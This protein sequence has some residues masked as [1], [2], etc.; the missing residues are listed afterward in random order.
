MNLSWLGG[1][2]ARADHSADGPAGPWRMSRVVGSGSGQEGDHSPAQVCCELSGSASG[3]SRDEPVNLRPD[4]Q[5]V[6]LHSFGNGID[7]AAVSGIAVCDLDADRRPEVL[8]AWYVTDFEDSDKN[9]RR[10]TVLRPDAEGELAIA[11]EFDLFQPHV[12]PPLSV[13][14][15]GTGE[16]VPGDFDGDGDTDVAVLPFFNDELWVFENDGGRLTGHVMLPFGINS[17]LNGISPPRGFA[18]DFDG[19]GRDELVYL[20]D[21]LQRFDGTLVHFW[22]SDGTISGMQRVLWEGGPGATAAVE[23]RALVVRDF[24]GDGRPDLCFS[25]IEPPLDT[26]V[27]ELWHNL[28]FS[29]G[30]FEVRQFRPEWNASDLAVADIFARCP[31]LLVLGG[32]DG[33]RVQFWAVDACSGQPLDY[34]PWMEVSGLAGISPQ[35]GLALEV[36]RLNG[37]RV[38]QIVARQKLGTPAESHQID[39]LAWEDEQFE[40]LEP[41]PVDAGGFAP[42]NN[43]QIQRPRALLLADVAGNRRPELIVGFGASPDNTRTASRILP[44]VVYRNGCLGDI[45]EDGRTSL[46]DLFTLFE[47]VGCQPPEYSRAADLNKDGCVDLLD[48]QLLMDDMGCRSTSD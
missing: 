11:E 10:L 5:T 29:T 42:P 14:S 9:R 45:N 7:L 46:A 24:D 40:L 13:F 25:G 12:I 31:P 15:N 21:P 18:A 20:A 38:P 33:A 19:D 44:L 35:F 32:P 6:V 8:V 41:P 2:G 16:V 3:G 47:H 34:Q 43:N 1:T 36:G 26:P 4:P 27:L 28:N 48:V 39:V 17:P 22:R 37:D 30:Q 23:T